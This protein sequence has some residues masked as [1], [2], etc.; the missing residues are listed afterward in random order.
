MNYIKNLYVI[1]P[2]KGNDI[3]RLKTTIFSLKKLKVGFSVNHLVIHYNSKFEI[4]EKIKSFKKTKTYNLIPIVIKKPGIYIAINQGLDYL[5]NDDSYI[6]L[7]SGDILKL[8][9]NKKIYLL[10]EDITLLNYKL[11]NN[12]KIKLFR[13][14]FS[15]MPYCHN[16]IIFKNNSLRYSKKY[17]IS[18]DYEYFMN[19]I[20]TKNIDLENCKNKINYEIKMIFE[21]ELGISSNSIFRKNF[22]NLLICF[23]YFGLK[24]V[25]FN[26]INKIFNIF[27]K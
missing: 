13:N 16:A 18:S 7:G 1:T 24:G 3:K 11:S 17:K 19:Y 20:K 14:K 15:G 25:F 26:L 27:F 5:R 21:A 8:E 4:I 23:K 22:E 12:K 6:V 9:N 10:K 2:F